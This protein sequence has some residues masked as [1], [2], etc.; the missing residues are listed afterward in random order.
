MD[1]QPGVA[2]GKGD[3]EDRT[4]VIYFEAPTPV[5]G[6][7]AGA[8]AGRSCGGATEA[9]EEWERDGFEFR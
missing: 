5:G 7:G 2:T 4:A 9:F 6:G 1:G 8:T 3:E